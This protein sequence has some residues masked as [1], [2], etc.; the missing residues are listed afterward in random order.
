M[1]VRIEGGRISDTCG[2]PSSRAERVATK[3][4]TA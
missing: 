4:P 3:P 1:V 2:S